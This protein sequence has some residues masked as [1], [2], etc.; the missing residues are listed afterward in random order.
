MQ[1][2]NTVRT[3]L[4]LAILAVVVFALYLT[5]HFD[6]PSPLFAAVILSA[7][8][9]QAAAGSYLQTAVIAV[10]SVCG[11]SAMQSLMS[12]QAAAGVAISAVQFLSAYGSVHLPSTTS[13]SAGVLPPTPPPIKDD[14]PAKSARAFFALATIY[15]I[16]TAA[17][18]AYLV[19]LPTY[20]AVLGN[21]SR[22]ATRPSSPNLQVR[23]ESARDQITRIAKANWVYHLAVA[24]IFTVTLV[25]HFSLWH[26]AD[27]HPSLRLSSRQ[28]LFWFAQRTQ[29][30]IL[31]SS[32]QRTFYSS[33]SV[34]FRA[35]YFAHSPRSSFGLALGSL[36]YQSLE[37]R[38][39]PYSSS[40]TFRRQVLP[41]RL[42]LYRTLA[43]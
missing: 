14:S 18:H 33:T 19:R 22:P 30:P 4:T 24:L 31:S 37:L 34:T 39:Y 16:L 7:A 36:P 12:G 20:I 23:S 41:S 38:S 42:V 11:P 3:R 17:A 32:Y 15:L 27:A 5:T 1:V 2:S 35:V 8:A 21:L 10:A 13:P 43:S 25:G 6:L 28:L 40:A 29:T 26:R 9:V